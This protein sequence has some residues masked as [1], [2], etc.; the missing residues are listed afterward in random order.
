MDLY[1]HSHTRLHVAALNK[2]EGLFL[3]LVDCASR[4]RFL[5][6]TNGMQFF[7][8]LFI[9][10]FISSVYMFRASSAHHQEIEFY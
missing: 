5:L 1:F 4:H 9:Y 2:T 3:Y 8:Y 10:L 7:V 6:I